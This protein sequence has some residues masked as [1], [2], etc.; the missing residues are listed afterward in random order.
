MAAHEVQLEL[1]TIRCPRCAGEIVLR[2]QADEVSGQVRLE[3]DTA[4]VSCG[5]SP[6]NESDQRL[7]VFRPGAAI[8]DSL[9][10]AASDFAAQL[11]AAQTRVDALLARQTDL[12]RDLQS[13]KRSVSRASAD[14]RRRKEELEAELRSDIT[15]LEGALADARAEVRRSEEATRGSVTPG[16][17]A[18][19]LE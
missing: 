14:E 1:R 17:R 8:G 6:W 16:K 7:L 12:E 10:G 3:L 4:C 5:V 15:R 9:A 11:S 2:I 18:I 19:E 13:A